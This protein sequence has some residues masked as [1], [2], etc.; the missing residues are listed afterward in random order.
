MPLEVQEQVDERAGT[1]IVVPHVSLSA[2][3][4]TSTEQ[5]NLDLNCNS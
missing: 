2:R 1:Y 5:G 3:R 4:G